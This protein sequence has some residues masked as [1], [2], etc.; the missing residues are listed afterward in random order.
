MGQK[1]RLHIKSFILE[2]CDCVA[3]MDG[4]QVDG[5]CG[6]L[7][8]SGDPGMLTPIGVRKLEAGHPVTGVTS[9]SKH[10]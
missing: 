10:S 2:L 3:E 4:I 5:D 8:E 7:V 6:E 9:T 1:F